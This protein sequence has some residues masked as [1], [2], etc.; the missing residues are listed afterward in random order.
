MTSNMHFS[1]I[2]CALLGALL[3]FQA[4]AQAK[5]P[6]MLARLSGVD[7][8]IQQA[9]ADGN[10]P[11]AVLVVGHDGAVIYRKAYGNR[12]LEPKVEPMTLRITPAWSRIWI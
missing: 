1:R 7:S 12:A 3:S 9:I 5:H 2:A 11:G 10:L 6:A 4:M 8:V